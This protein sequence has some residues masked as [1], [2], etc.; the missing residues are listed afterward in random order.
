MYLHK[1]HKHFVTAH[2]KFCDGF[3][4]Y[5]NKSIND[6]YTQIPSNSIYTG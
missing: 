3:V 2:N 1:F 6:S 5:M 4:F